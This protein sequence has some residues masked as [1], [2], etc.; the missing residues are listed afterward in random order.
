MAELT[1]STLESYDENGRVLK[2]T[3]E[4]E[5]DMP[6]W[7]HDLK[8]EAVKALLDTVDGKDFYEDGKHEEFHK[9]LDEIQEI[10]N[11]LRGL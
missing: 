1:K 8:L 3:L 7:E 2:V 6:F 4:G 9:H 11:A 5:T 10:L